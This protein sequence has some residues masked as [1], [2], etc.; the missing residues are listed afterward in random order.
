M[1]PTALEIKISALQR[2]KGLYGWIGSM[3]VDDAGS[4]GTVENFLFCEST[5]I[6]KLERYL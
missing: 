6:S 5:S 2:H 3:L 4:P 1:N